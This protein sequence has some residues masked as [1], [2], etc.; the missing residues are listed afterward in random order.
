[1]GAG[2]ASMRTDKGSTDDSFGLV[3]L[4]SIGP[5]I[6]VMLLGIFFQPGNAA[7]NSTEAVSAPTP[8]DAV[9]YFAKELPAAA[10]E[11]LT[12]LVA[13][14][15][16]FLLFQLITRRYR[17]HQLR[18][19]GMGFL[20]TFIGLVVFLT[21]VNVGFIPVGHQLGLRLA[22]TPS[23]YKWILVP[24]SMIVGYFIVRAEPAVHVLNKQVE[25]ITNGAISEKTM[26]R[27]LA[28]GMAA[29]LGI[30]IVRILL[31]IPI[32]Y[33]LIPCYALAIILTFFV[34]K[35]FTGIAF[36]SGGVCSGPMTS[37]FLLPLAMGVA[38]GHGG[39]LMKDA[40]GIV[41]MVAMTPLVVLQILGIAYKLK[42][43]RAAGKP[44]AAARFPDAG[45]I[46]VW[47]EPLYG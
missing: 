21:G 29:A 33:I 6:A 23:P 38:E 25:D 2:V 35:I 7:V 43:S 44:A 9:L 45:K 27:C 37:T 5:I 30:T 8:R 10:K 19:I 11:V 4:C 3:A 42:T 15:F 28:I 34:P 13:L 12:A 39:D 32:L 46:Y 16:F 47:E 18:R 24:F 36:D 22:S 26:L 40:F 14:V 1:M 17:M 31:S 41:A 20:Y